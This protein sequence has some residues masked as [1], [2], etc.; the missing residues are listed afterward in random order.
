MDHGWLTTR[1]GPAGDI[2]QKHLRVE[3]TPD[4]DGTN[5]N[6]FRNSQASNNLP[7]TSNEGNLNIQFAGPPT[8]FSFTYRNK[9][10]EGGQNQFTA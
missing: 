4:N 9:G 3:V 7:A 8:S 5:G 6:R 2:E 10:E 1:D